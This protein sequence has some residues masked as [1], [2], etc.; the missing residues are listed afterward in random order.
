MKSFKNILIV[1]LVV[2]VLIAVLQNRQTVDTKFLFATV[3]MP[4]ALLLLVTLGVGFA[5]GM[6]TSAKLL[7]GKTR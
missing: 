6:L 2:L 4:R 7:R 1:V 5:A 3:S